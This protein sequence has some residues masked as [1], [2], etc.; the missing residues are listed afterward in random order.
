MSQSRSV[1]LRIRT[2]IL[3]PRRLY[4]N[5]KKSSFA[6]CLLFS[7]LSSRELWTQWNQF[8]H[9]QLLF[10]DSQFILTKRELGFSNHSFSM[11]SKNTRGLVP[12][13]PPL[14]VGD[15]VYFVSNKDKSLARDHYI[16]I[17]TDAS[18][19]FVKS[20]FLQSQ[21]IWVLPYVYLHCSVPP[22][23]P[24]NLPRQGWGAFT[25]SSC[26]TLCPSTANLIPICTTTDY[27]H[28]FWWWYNA[29][30]P[31]PYPASNLYPWGAVHQCCCY[32]PVIEFL[33]AMF[34]S[35]TFWPKTSNTA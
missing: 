18:W 27:H 16:V 6:S 25:C 31:L 30:C 21:I 29:W 3:S 8:T 9:E 10:S 35:G 5:L 2:R 19:C 1:V 14:H 23:K 7:G 32:W 24:F 12:N 26:S 33:R 4:V 22:P 13:S 20:L 34:I 15:L 17:S 11:K 28:A